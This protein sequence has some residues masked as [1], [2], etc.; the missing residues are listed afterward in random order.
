M[1][2]TAILFLEVGAVLLGLGVL[3]ALALRAGIS[4]IPLYLIAGLAFGTGGVL[5]LATSEEFIS[6]GA[7][8]GVVLLLLT[9]GLEYNADELVT[10]LKSN[11]RAGIVDLVANAAPGAI[12]AL[13][14][15]WGPVAAV[16]MAGVTY[17]TSSGITAKVLSDLG[18]IGNRETPTVLSLLVFEDL[19]M[20]VYLPIL[21]ALLAGLSLVSGAVTV[22]IALGTVSV[23]LVVALRFGRFIEAFVSSPNNEVLLLKIVGLALL[24]AG[25]AQQLQVS[26][27]VGAFLVGIALSGQLAHDAQALLSPL[28]DLFAAVFFV[29]FGLQT[30]PV[31]ILPVA[32]LAALLAL[33]SMITK[34][35]TG[36]YAARRAGIAK[37]GQA[38]AGIALIPRGEFNIVIAGLAVAAGVHPD[39]GPLAAAYVLIL[40]AFG[41]LA[42]KAVQPLIENIAKRA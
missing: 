10:S 41:P 5:P 23:V 25:I 3:G 15:G 24:V 2:H 36:I 12:C 22:A 33:I 32:G 7:E 37:A 42:A 19:T 38:R 8:M 26:A 4:P 14:L 31:K 35:M 28:R 13:L 9:L 20:A 16:A 11:A 1:H 17:A 21:T 27:A 39:L 30:D 40:A 18:W 6:V 34:L 29:F